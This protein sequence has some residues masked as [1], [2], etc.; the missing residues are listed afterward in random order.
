MVAL[1]AE[2]R[3]DAQPTHDVSSHRWIVRP[4]HGPA[5]G[6][7]VTNAVIRTI[8]GA[9]TERMGGNDVLN[10]LEAERLLARALWANSG[11]AQSGMPR[12]PIVR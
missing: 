4:A 7:D 12:H 10:Q 9:I 11:H 2:S 5:D 1:S 6:I 8:A 3:I